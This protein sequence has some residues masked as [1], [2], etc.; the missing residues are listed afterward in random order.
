[1]ENCVD[2]DQQVFFQKPADLSLHS[3]KIK[4]YKGSAGGL[5]FNQFLKYDYFSH[6]LH[7]CWSDNLLIY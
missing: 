7:G 3:F 5:H 6:L 1:M 2:P 4:I